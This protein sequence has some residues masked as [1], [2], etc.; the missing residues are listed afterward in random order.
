MSIF[1][2]WIAKKKTPAEC[3]RVGEVLQMFLDGEFDGD[4][5]WI[6]DHLDECQDC[7]FEASVIQDLKDAVAR[8]GA[9]DPATRD[10]LQ[11][12]ADRLARGDLDVVDGLA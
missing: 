4:A 7:G 11:L 8:E 12:F 2:R 10:R 3:M 9:V 1:S 5:S 6:R